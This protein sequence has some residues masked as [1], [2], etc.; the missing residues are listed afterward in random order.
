ME[1]EGTEC[2]VFITVFVTSSCKVKTVASGNGG[3]KRL[4]R[5]YDK[6]K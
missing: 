4:I 1:A 2:R 6:T 3:G 5:A